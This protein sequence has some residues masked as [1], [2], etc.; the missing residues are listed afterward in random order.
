MSDVK[1]EMMRRV[2]D[3]RIN[4]ALD[5]PKAVMRQSGG[6]DGR[7]QPVDAPEQDIRQHRAIADQD[8]HVGEAIHTLVDYLVGSGFNIKPANVPYTDQEQTDEDISDFKLLVETSNFNTVLGEW[9]WHALVDGT[10]FVEIVV[11]DDVFKP[12]V[13][14]DAANEH[15]NG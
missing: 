8:P 15:P 13:A 7:P 4:F 14:S 3:G 6:S 9:V 12:K 11:E 2:S 1:A 5:S 10:A